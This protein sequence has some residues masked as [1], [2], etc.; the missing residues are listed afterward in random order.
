MAK[1]IEGTENRT[2]YARALML[3]NFIDQMSVDEFRHVG[4]ANRDMVAYARYKGDYELP[5]VTPLVNQDMKEIQLQL[6]VRDMGGFI[7]IEHD[8]EKDADVYTF[9]PL[10][11]MDRSYEMFKARTLGRDQSIDFEPSEHEISLAS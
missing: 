2:Q 1:E 10:A 3:A 4:T 7:H 9:V 6:L 11:E 8:R 5:F